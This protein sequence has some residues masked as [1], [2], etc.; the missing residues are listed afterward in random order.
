MTR[1]E[2]IREKAISDQK[3]LQESFEWRGGFISGATWSDENPK[4]GLVSI[5]KVCEWIENTDFEMTYID[6]EGFFDKEKFIKEL[7][8]VIK[9]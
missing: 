8:K 7:L 5:D 9:E 2:Q 1:K 3:A 4:E 6:G